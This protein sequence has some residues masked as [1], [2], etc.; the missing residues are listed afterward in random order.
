VRALAARP[1]Q[2][3]GETAKGLRIRTRGAQA[4]RQATPCAWLRCRHQHTCA[5]GTGTTGP[6][7]PQATAHMQAPPSAAGCGRLSSAPQPGPPH[8]GTSTQQP[9]DG[10]GHGPPGP[11][12]L[13]PKPERVNGGQ[14]A[15]C[16]PDGESGNVAGTRIRSSDRV[17]FKLRVL[18]GSI[19]PSLL[20][21]FVRVLFSFSSFVLHPDQLTSLFLN[22]LLFFFLLLMFLTL[23]ISLRYRLFI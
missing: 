21:P 7:P 1:A 14:W 23:L 10:E 11:S 3:K 4:I 16:S 18:I 5:A 2:W 8:S 6:R 9:D 19:N 13:E 15:V 22:F 12:V 20:T 17:M